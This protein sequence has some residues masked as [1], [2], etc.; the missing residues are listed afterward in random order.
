MRGIFQSLLL[1]I[2]QA[3]G[4]ELARMVQ[5]LKVENRVLLGKLPKRVEVTPRE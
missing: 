3:T 1:L 2:A 4:R 5:Y